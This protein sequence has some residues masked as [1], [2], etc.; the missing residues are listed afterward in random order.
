M[1]K[2]D[3][4]VLGPPGAGSVLIETTAARI[5]SDR[6]WKP[7]EVTTFVG[8][9]RGPACLAPVQRHHHI[10]RGPLS[11]RRQLGP[12]VCLSEPQVSQPSERIR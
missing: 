12:V 2:G 9:R 11:G 3:V 4:G 10:D 5:T 1:D 7:D 6:V 8:A